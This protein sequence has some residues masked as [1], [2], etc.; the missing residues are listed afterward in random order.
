MKIKIKR[1]LIL[2]GVKARLGKGNLPP[3]V[4]ETQ[5]TVYHLKEGE[6]KSGMFLKRLH[7]DSEEFRDRGI[8]V[9]VEEVK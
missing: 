1:S 8:E 6:E 2:R 9:R 5:I 7:D 4:V 3:G